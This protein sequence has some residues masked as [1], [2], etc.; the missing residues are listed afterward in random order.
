MPYPA[1]TRAERI[2]DAVVHVF[3]IGGSVLA[4]AALFVVTHGTLGAGTLAATIVYSVTLIA[5]LTASGLYHMAAHT[6]LRPILRRIDHAAIYFKIAGTFTPLAVILGTASG[7]L[8]LAVVWLIALAGAARKLMARRGRI[9]TSALPYVALGWVGVMFLFPLTKIAPGPALALIAAGGLTY[10]AGVLFYNWQ[11]LRYA[12]AIW[13]GF[14]L[15]ATG[16]F[17]GAIATSV[18][19]LPG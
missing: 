9:P 14:V 18:M 2:A 15:V 3:G 19:A 5:M 11:G 17:F 8:I 1:F 12:T 6:R 4:V 13:H 16:C 7:Y 10:T